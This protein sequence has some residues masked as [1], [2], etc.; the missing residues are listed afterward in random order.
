MKKGHLIMISGP[1][2]V[3]KGT[4]RKILFDQYQEELDLVFSI[5]KTTRDRRPGE[6]DG[7]DYH[8]VSDQDFEAS[9]KDNDFLEY[10]GYVG[11]YYGTPLSFINDH[12]AQGH[13]VV[14]EIEVQGGMQVIEKRPDVISFF[15][16]PPSIEELKNR[17]IHRGTE[18]IEV[19]NNRLKKAEEELT[20]AQYYT[21]N[22]VN[23]D[24]EAC[25]EEIKNILKTVL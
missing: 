5:S 25:A 13:N 19:I 8:Y 10:A 24:R 6:V 3:G 23:V 1:S 16:L 15:I 20:Y 21:Y 17:L 14:L 7:V 4:V 9:I 18:D 22:V 11:H 2:G 12:I